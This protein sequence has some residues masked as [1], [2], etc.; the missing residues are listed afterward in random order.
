[1]TDVNR[2]YFEGLMADRKLSLRGLAKR[3]GLSHSQLSL[4]FSG[5]RRL[6]LEEASQLASIFSVPLAEVVKA[7]GVD[8]LPSGDLHVPV[9][10]SMRSDG[11]VESTPD[12]AAERATTPCPMPEDTVAVQVRSAGGPLGWCDG[13][14]LFARRADTVELSGLGRACLAKLQGGHMVVATLARGYRDGTWNLSGF[15]CAESSR[16]EWASPVLL[17]RP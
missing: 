7:A 17:I 5:T 3:M 11:T 1:M 9:I 15:Y 6:K 10:G 2:R 14:L 12:G 13:W 4:A 16:L 8:L